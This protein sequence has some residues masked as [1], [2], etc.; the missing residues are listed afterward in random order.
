MIGL[1]ANNELNNKWKEVAVACAILAF[2]WQN[3]GNP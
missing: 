1:L 3:R 2:S